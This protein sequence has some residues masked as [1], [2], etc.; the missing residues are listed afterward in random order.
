MYAEIVF[1]IPVNNTYFYSV[2]DNLKSQIQKGIRVKVDFNNRLTTGYVINLKNKIEDESLISK[3][4]PVI[5]VIDT[6]P[7]FTPQM[8]KLAQ[9]ISEYYITSIGE[10]LKVMIPSATKEK[11][12]EIKYYENLSGKVITLTPVQNRIYNEILKLDLPAYALIYGVTGSGKT[13]IY[14][15]L[16]EY[17]VKKK[18]KLSIL[19]LKSHLQN[20]LSVNF[21]KNFP[22]RKSQ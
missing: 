2:P 14:L 3:L 5:S 21:M 13:E 16:I 20:R 6:I 17:F 12:P 22:Q 15:K 11:K 10:A 8:Y 19:Y 1:P 9:W 18:S 4:K 7:V